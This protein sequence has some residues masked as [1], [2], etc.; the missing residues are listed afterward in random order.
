M[1]NTPKVDRDYLQKQKISFYQIASQESEAPAGA[2]LL[3]LDNISWSSSKQACL[4]N[5]HDFVH[6]TAATWLADW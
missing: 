1:H 3:K 5:L 2:D 6:C 4:L